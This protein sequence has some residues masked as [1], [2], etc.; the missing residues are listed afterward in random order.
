MSKRPKATIK[1]TLLVWARET[2][3]FDLSTAA[4][5]LDVDEEKLAAWEMG[6]DQPS[7]PQLR[8]AAELYKRPL[9]VLYLQEQ[10]LTF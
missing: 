8:K 2:A 3:G 7:I 9:A 4:E 1:P 5:K 10:P 6:E